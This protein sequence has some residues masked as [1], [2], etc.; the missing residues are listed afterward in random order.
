MKSV[1][2]MFKC[3]PEE[4][5]SIRTTSRD[6]FLIGHDREKIKDW[7]S[8]MS[9]FCQDIKA[10]HQNTEESLSLGDKRHASDPSP[11]LD[12]SSTLEAASFTSSRTSLPNMHFTEKY[13]PGFRQAHLSQDFSSK[14]TQ[15]KEEEGYYINPRS[16]ILELEKNIDSSDSGESIERGSPDKVFK[17][18][19][20]P[21]M[22]MKSCVFKETSHRSAESKEESQALLETQDEGLHPQEKDSENDLHLS[23]DNS[24]VHT[25][26]DKKGS[27]SL[28]VVHNIPD[29]CQVQK[30]DVFLSP[31]D[32]INHLALIEA[33]GR[34]CVAQWIGPPHL[35]C[36]FCHGD[37]LLAVNDLKPQSLQEVSLFLSRSIQKEKIKLTIGRIPNSKKFHAITCACP[38]KYQVVAPFHLV[39][40]GL[41]RAPKK[42][43]A[44][45]KSQQ[46]E[47]G[48]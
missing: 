30:L 48:Q 13:S 8:F 10:A 31:P 6:Y 16:V 4:V 22:S 35:G 5:M 42:T 15:D 40:P 33:A 25:M 34:I 29:E 1:Q 24:E 36:L 20:C 26:N 43:P 14:T 9:S 7:V 27:T 32:V 46:K 17:R 28:T 44:I 19:E 38:L 12:P 45:R 41:E 37:H 39:K 3:H 21:Y 47:T 11:V 18:T 2:K 23:P